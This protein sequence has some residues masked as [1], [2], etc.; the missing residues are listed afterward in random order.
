ML[1]LA[2]EERSMPN[3][4]LIASWH[5]SV[6]SLRTANTE[7]VS[8]RQTHNEQEPPAVPAVPLAFVNS[9]NSAQARFASPGQ[10]IHE[11][12]HDGPSPEPSAAMEILEHQEGVWYPAHLVAYLYSIQAMK[13]E[14]WEQEEYEGGVGVGVAVIDV[15]MKWTKQPDWGARTSIGKSSINVTKILNT[16]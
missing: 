16:N 14:L 11:N 15:K 12:S 7:R 4:I 8:T 6:I 1:P 13:G 10:S 2:R 3:Q 9:Y 5:L